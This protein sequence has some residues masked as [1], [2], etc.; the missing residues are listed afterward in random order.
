MARLDLHIP[1]YK[2]AGYWAR[3]REFFSNP[4]KFS[5]EKGREVSDFFYS[6]LL[7]KN[8]FIT[9]NPKVIQHILQTNQKN[10][11]KSPAYDQLKLA[12]GNGL[13]TSEGDFWRKQRRL[14]QPAF[15]RQKLM[16]LFNMMV[17]EADHYLKDL[18][19]R[20][21]GDEPLNISLEMMKVTADIVLKTLFNSDN[22]TDQQDLYHT[23]SA[24]Q[25]YIMYCVH[26]PYMIPWT[27][28]NGRRRRFFKELQSFDAILQELIVARRNSDDPPADLLTMLLEA[29]DEET[30]EGMSDRQLRD[31]AIT[32]FA[33]GHETSANGLAWTLY[34]LAQHPA[35]FAKVR[36]EAQRV[37]GDGLPGFEDLR[38]LQYTRQVIEE[39]MR[40]YPPA[41]AIGREA[42]GADEVLGQMIPKKSIL[43]ISIYALHRHAD[44]W[45]D[46]ERFDPERFA[47]ELVKE[48]SRWAYLP[49]GAGP[50]MCIG[51]NFAMM[52]MQLLLALLVRSFDFS[53]APGF[54]AEKQ[55]LITLKPKHGILMNVKQA[56]R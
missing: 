13:I 31:E 21:Q 49:F 56:E 46:P 2:G 53:I 25:E 32:I 41:W 11:R 9:S 18:S 26:Q 3:Q 10:Y 44:L 43:F 20:C 6:Y 28:L 47:P 23:M 27:F 16:G 36:A 39:G 22:Y 30:G 29:R 54:V 17:G 35:V 37:L 50:R 40:L 42:I 14:A 51:N 5:T 12:L 55:P 52:E 24:T 1:N 8:I 48:R 7:F 38:D 45:P 19:Q 33:A 4:L 15:H 34:L